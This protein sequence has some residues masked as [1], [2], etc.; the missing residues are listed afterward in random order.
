MRWYGISFGAQ[1]KEDLSFGFSAFLSQQFQNYTEDVGLA[2]G[3]TLNDGGLRVGGNSVTTSTSLGATAYHFVFRLGAL[4]RINPRWQLGFMFQ[5]P[6]APLSQNGRVFRRTTLAVSGGDSEYFLYDQG[7]IATHLPIPFEI[8]SGFEFKVNALTTLSADLA[9]A[10]PVRNRSV[11][12]LP[13][14]VMNLPANLGVYFS[15]STAR[16]WT[17]NVAVGAE[18]LFGKAVVAGGLFTNLS[19]APDI[20]PNP[21]EYSPDQVSTFGAS[22][23]VGLDTKGYRLTLGANTYFGRGDAI[24][25]TLDPDANV[26]GY[27]RTKANKTAVVLYIAGDVSVASKGAKQVQEKLHNKKAN[28]QGDGDDGPDTSATPTD[29]TPTAPPSPPAS[30]E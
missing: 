23:S 20:P 22:F 16:R 5:P 8:R 11:F 18:H 15:N 25:F 19:A 10:G 9:V 24:A 6:G 30:V 2:A 26:T 17:P 7:D 4:Y 21:T 3:G 27:Q 29:E 28:T 13:E 12:E 1:A 14:Q